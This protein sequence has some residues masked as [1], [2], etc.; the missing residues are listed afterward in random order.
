MNKKTKIFASAF[1]GVTAL[2]GGFSPSLA[3]SAPGDE[4]KLPPKTMIMEKSGKEYYILSASEATG[5]GGNVVC[6]PYN[7]DPSRTVLLCLN[8]DTGVGFAAAINSEK[9]TGESYH[10]EKGTRLDSEVYEGAQDVA[11]E[12]QKNE[13]SSLK[14]QRNLFAANHVVL[15]LII[16]S[17]VYFLRGLSKKNKILEKKAKAYDQLQDLAEGL[18]THYPLSSGE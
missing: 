8:A 7:E 3:V 14:T 18:K 17:L 12:S 10:F 15:L 16:A 11:K 5:G 9:F 2:L 6:G 4:P 13:I 1:L